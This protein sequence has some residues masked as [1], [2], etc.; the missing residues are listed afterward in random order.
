MVTQGWNVT[1]VYS[2]DL[3]IEFHAQTLYY[4]DVAETSSTKS[5]WCLPYS[6]ALSMPLCCQESQDIEPPI[7]VHI[8]VRDLPPKSFRTLPAPLIKHEMSD[9]TNL[10]TKI[11]VRAPI[12]V[13]STLRRYGI[14]ARESV[15][16]LDLRSL[17]LL[18]Q[19]LS[20]LVQTA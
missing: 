5:K 19:Q 14:D 18:L 10:T 20:Q 1:S 3:Q 9:L 12:T 16:R 13:S 15:L 11:N 2:I 6:L 17:A 4:Y 8:S 7:R